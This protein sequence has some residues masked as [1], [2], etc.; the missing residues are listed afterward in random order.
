V[1]RNEFV[2]AFLALSLGLV[3]IRAIYE[4]MRFGRRK[5]TLDEE[6]EPTKNEPVIILG[7]VLVIVFYL[8]MALYVIL[9]SLGLQNGLIES[10]IQLRFP[11]DSSVQ[12]MGMIMMVFGY[13]VVFWGIH[14]IE[15]DRLVTWG[16]YR[17]ARHPQYVG[18]FIIFAGFF[19]LLL[20]LVAFVP[21]FSIPGEIRMAT[22]E[23]QLLTKKYGDIYGNYQR[24]TGKFIPRI[25]SVK[26]RNHGQKRRLS[27]C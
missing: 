20:N 1:L 24:I 12:V 27:F 6:M 23:E 18:Y 8:E 14:S 26:R 3:L 17:Y 10:C 21:L 22:L 7:G 2:A 4:S 15:Y 19:L 25:R 13:V 11:F 5:K 16:P 9:F